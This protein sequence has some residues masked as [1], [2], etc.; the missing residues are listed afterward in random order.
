MRFLKKLLICVYVFLGAFVIYC[1]VN[2][3]LQQTEPTTLI[4]CVFASAG[5]ESIISFLIKSAESKEER[6][7]KKEDNKEDIDKEN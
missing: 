4:G 1:C 7:N 5:V 2:F 3:T 6:K